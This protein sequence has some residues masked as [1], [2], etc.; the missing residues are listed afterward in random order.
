MPCCSRRNK[1][2][3]RPKQKFS[4]EIERSGETTKVSRTAGNS[5]PVGFEPT[6]GDPIGLAGRRLNHSA[7]VSSADRTH[8]KH[9]ASNTLLF[10]IRIFCE[11]TMSPIQWVH[12]SV[13]RA[14][15]CRSA[16][17]WFKSGCA[18]LV[19]LPAS[20]SGALHERSCFIWQASRTIT[21]FHSSVG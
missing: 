12:S 13:V 4:L 21:C 9:N 20:L 19:M 5:T 11:P 7:K 1:H 16:G 2:A 3:A 10:S 18:L 6:R 8:R 14:A 15:D 17:P